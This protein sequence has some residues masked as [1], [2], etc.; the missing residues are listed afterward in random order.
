MDNLKHAL[1]T[2]RGYGVILVVC[3]ILALWPDRPPEPQA[4]RP[5]PDPPALSL[6]AVQREA[7]P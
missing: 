5:Q 7:Q 3:V 1:R 6:P 4:H 2:S